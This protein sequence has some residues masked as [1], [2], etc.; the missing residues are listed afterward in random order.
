MELL[1]DNKLYNSTQIEEITKVERTTVRD[2]SCG[3]LYPELLL[4]NPI[5]Y[6]K[7]RS[8][9]KLGR[10]GTNFGTV[11]AAQGMIAPIVIDPEGIEHGVT[12]IRE[13]SRRFC[14]DRRHLTG[15]I[16]CNNKSHL[17]FYLKS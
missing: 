8:N 5:M 14:L 2:I 12:N 3:A 4:V 1:S 16:K 6:E 7:M 9:Q 17:G 11:L 13:F 10:V 15:V